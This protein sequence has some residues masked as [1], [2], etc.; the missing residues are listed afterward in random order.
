MVCQNVAHFD[1]GKAATILERRR[2]PPEAERVIHVIDAR[3]QPTQSRTQLV[4][5][6]LELIVGY[7]LW[8]I[9]VRLDRQ[10][11]FSQFRQFC[12][13]FNGPQ[14]HQCPGDDT[15]QQNHMHQNKWQRLESH[16]NLGHGHSCD[17]FL[18][19]FFFLTV[20]TL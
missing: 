20:E 10:R 7:D 5:D 15:R 2:S 13:R 17:Q 12:L 11:F 4:Q 1:T 9:V 16:W 8:P 18:A 14:P 6:F 19:G 3:A